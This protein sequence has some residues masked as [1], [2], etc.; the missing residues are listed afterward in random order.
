MFLWDDKKYDETKLTEAGKV[1]YMQLQSVAEQRRQI[2]L[3]IQNLDILEKS[4][5]E[6]LKEDLPEAEIKEEEA[7]GTD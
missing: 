5:M 3:Q 7:N 4:H 2:S 1:A 6:V